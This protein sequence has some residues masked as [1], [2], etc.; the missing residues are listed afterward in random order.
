MKTIHTARLVLRPLAAADTDALLPLFTDWDVI[1]WLSAPPWPYARSDMDMFFGM[2]IGRGDEAHEKFRVITLDGAAIGAVS[3]D[4][5]KRRLLGYWLGKPF[6][7]R[8]I[9]TEAALGLVRDYFATAARRPLTSG[10]FDGNAASLKV[11]E[12]LGFVVQGRK[13]QFCHPQAQDLPLIETE[14]TRVRFLALHGN[15][16]V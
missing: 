12:N 6:W 4:G 10:A 3:I 5:T 2:L 1:R 14:L 11:Q 15:G 9:M 16:K 8:G 7:G 13:P